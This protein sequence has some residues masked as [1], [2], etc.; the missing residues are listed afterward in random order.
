MEQSR[1]KMEKQA[2]KLL[3]QERRLASRTYTNQFFIEFHC[4][5]KCF[6]LYFLATQFFYP[7][8][9]VNLLQDTNAY[10]CRVPETVTKITLTYCKHSRHCTL[11]Q[12][13]FTLHEEQHKKKKKSRNHSMLLS[14]L[15]YL[16]FSTIK[17]FYFA[18]KTESK[19]EKY[20]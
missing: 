16:E 14:K 3:V 10:H 8:M 4:Q 5:G 6:S 1:R 7:Q 18:N 19:H 20:L 17:Q 13:Q 15:C 9:Y 12:L 2:F 11:G